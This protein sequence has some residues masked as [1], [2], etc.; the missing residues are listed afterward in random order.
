MKK[1]AVKK[2]TKKIV[3]KTTK[4]VVKQD[5]DTIVF[6][7]TIEV[8]MLPVLQGEARA[9]FLKDWEVETNKSKIN[10]IFVDPEGFIELCIE[11]DLSPSQFFTYI[12]REAIKAYDEKKQQEAPAKIPQEVPPA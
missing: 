7:K 6:P 4:K 11:H 8:G 12:L 2:P 5:D 3:K 9:Q 10:V 1:K